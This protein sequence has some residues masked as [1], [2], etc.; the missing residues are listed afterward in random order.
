MHVPTNAFRE[1]DIRG[2]ADRD[3]TSEVARAIGQGFA[4]MLGA[5]AR[6]LRIAVGRDC[7]LSSDRLFGA[8]VDGMTAAGANVVDIGV[9]P[10][11]MLY[12]AVHALGTDGGLMI[13][14]SHNPGDENG[15]KMMRGKASF[16]GGDI[17]TLRKLVEEGRLATARTPGTLQR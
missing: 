15:F 2:V 6:S 3:L 14:G 17:Q 7:R 16:F 11:P 4:S 1:Y 12:G 8:V 9:G 5:A 10:T 13:T